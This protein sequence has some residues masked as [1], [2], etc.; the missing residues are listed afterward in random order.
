MNLNE[1]ERTQPVVMMSWFE[2]PLLHHLHCYFSLFLKVAL[3]GPQPSPR[4]CR[5][6]KTEE[7]RG[8][9]F[10]LENTYVRL[11]VQ[12]RRFIWLFSGVFKHVPQHFFCAYKKAGSMDGCGVQRSS[13]NRQVP[14]LGTFCCSPE[15]FSCRIGRFSES[16]SLRS[17]KNPNLW[18]HSGRHQLN[19]NGLR[20]N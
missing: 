14:T 8:W 15:W 10:N 16:H 5:N 17:D 19:V 4:G 9:F 7:L 6:S 11:N 18:A 1:V 3:I 12:N 2:L 20:Y 13:L